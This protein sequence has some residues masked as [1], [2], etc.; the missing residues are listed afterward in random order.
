MI[1][2]FVEELPHPTELLRDARW[3]ESEA[4]YVCGGPVG[5]DQGW[6]LYVPLTILNAQEGIKRLAPLVAES[7]LQFKYVKNLLLL[8]K[9]NAGMFGYPQIGKGFVVYVPSPSRAFLAAVK[10]AVAPY[11]GECPA[12]PFAIPFGDDLPLFYRYGSYTRSSVT[13]DGV[14]QEDRRDDAASAVPPGIPD[15]LAPFT[16][17][18][19]EDERVGAFLRR[20]PAVEALK[21]EGK[22]GLFLA[23]Q[24]CTDAVQEVVLKVSYHRGQVQPD[25]SDGTTLLRRE[26]DFYRLLATRGLAAVAPGLV[27]VLDLT[28]KVILVLEYV[29][30][31][32]LLVRKLR[33]ELMVE[34]LEHCWGVIDAVHAA[35]LYLGD[36]KLANFIGTAGGPVRVLDFE[37]AGVMGQSLPTGR[38]FFFPSPGY[39]DLAALDRAHFLASVLYPYEGGYS[40]GDRQLDLHDWLRRE[41]ADP[42]EAWSLERLGRVLASGYPVA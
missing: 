32:N 12:V 39:G 23:L 8:R 33:G 4:W 34:D 15:E 18:I 14:E 28:R 27:D 41:P 6:K 19:H 42:A 31:D 2:T 22:G 29:P 37:S 17:P 20:Y 10:A 1:P 24:L 36:A 35:G 3:Q 38:T 40:F 9:L 7:G 30:G 13:L 26:L 25:G 16:L 5:V 11:A 21:Q